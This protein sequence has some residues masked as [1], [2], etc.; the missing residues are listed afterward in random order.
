MKSMMMEEKI[1]RA[2]INIRVN[3]AGIVYVS[4]GDIEQA[5]NIDTNKTAAW[6]RIIRDY[7]ED[8]DKAVRVID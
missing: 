2:E 4:I 6:G 7:R 3:K 1:V 5:L 8:D